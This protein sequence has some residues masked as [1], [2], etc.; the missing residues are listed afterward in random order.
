MMMTKR[1]KMIRIGY[2]IM[3]QNDESIEDR[4]HGGELEEI[5]GTT[6]Q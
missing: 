3:N 6:P 4:N 1:E 2:L 5:G